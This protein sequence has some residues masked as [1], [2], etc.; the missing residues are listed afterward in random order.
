MSQKLIHIILGLFISAMSLFSQDSINAEVSYIE[1]VAKINANPARIN[2]SILEGDRLSTEKGRVEVKINGNYVRLNNFTQ[3]TFISLQEESIS[4]EINFG[5]VYIQAEDEI[6]I[7]TPHEA[8]SVTGIYRIEVDRYGTKKFRNPALV[9]DFDRWELRRERELTRGD[10]PSYQ[11][12]SYYYRYHYCWYPPI[13]YYWPSTIWISWSI[14]FYP[15]YYWWPSYWFAGYYWWSYYRWYPYHWVH[16]SYWGL[17]RFYVGW[18]FSFRPWWPYPRWSY[19]SYW[20]YYRHFLYYPYHWRYYYVEWPFYYRPR[21]GLTTIYKAQLQKPASFSLGEGKVFSLNSVS[22][23]KV[24]LNGLIQPGQAQQ[25]SYSGQ[26]NQ[27]NP[28]PS[29]S[30]KKILNSEIYPSRLKIE[31]SA[32]NLRSSP[33]LSRTS[34]NLSRQTITTPSSRIMTRPSRT[35]ST[36][37]SSPGIRRV[38]HSSLPTSGGSITRTSRLSDLQRLSTS[39]GVSGSPRSASSPRL[40]VQ[41]RLYAPSRLSSP[42]WS[43][44]PSRMSPPLRSF[45][46]PSF[47]RPLSGSFSR[48]SFGS[49]SPSI[50]RP[51]M[52]SRPATGSIRRR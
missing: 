23:G 44:A 27:R 2:D 42:S 37:S 45:S 25:F 19:F 16:Y 7:Q 9:D 17:P 48:P 35:P 33:T 43:S 28:S 15:D 38:S 20:G 21:P 34:S 6:N 1:G 11:Q 22:A 31:S 40:S 26:I 8:F 32:R 51:S 36:R 4:L 24:A 46:S 3:V 52:G 14:G 29:L 5:E 10:E 41:P 47:S 39:S 50:S 12:K 49:F 13:V 18:F 30:E